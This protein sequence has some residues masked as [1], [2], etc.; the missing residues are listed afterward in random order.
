MCCGLS[1]GGGLVDIHKESD[2]NVVDIEWCLIRF[3][4][5]SYL[6]KVLRISWQ[7]HAKTIPLT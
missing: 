1:G 4:F 2:K 5:E 3:D 6:P 7:L